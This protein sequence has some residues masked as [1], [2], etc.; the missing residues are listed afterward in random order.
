V[1]LDDGLEQSA[2]RFAGQVALV[3]N[4][5]RLTYRELDAAANRF[6]AGLLQAGMAPGDAVVVHLEN[7]VEAVIAIF[8]TLRAGGVFIPVGATVKADKL[9]YI[10]KDS[11][12]AV[13]IANERVAAALDAARRMGARV[14]LG[15]QVG[16]DAA[17][18]P[19]AVKTFDALAATP[20]SGRPAARRIDVDLASLIYTSGSTGRPKGVMLTHLAMVSAL[21]SIG[22]YLENTDADVIL[23]VL[24]LSF[25]YGLY[26]VFLAFQ[27]GA[28]LVL[29][30]SFV[31]PTVMLDLLEQEGVTAL[32]LVPTLACHLLKH[33][34]RAV[35]T[36][37]RYISSTGAPLPPAHTKA[38]R[39]QLDGVRIFSM[40]GLTECK[41]VA[42]L[43][44][45]DVEARPDSVGRPMPNVEVFVADEVGRLSESG[46]GELVVRGS[47]LMTGYWRAPEE[48]RRALRPGLLPGQKLLFTGDRF[49]IDDRG[50]MY[51]LG[52][53]DD[54]IKSRGQRVSPK[55]VENAL[56]AV[57][58]VTGAAVVGTPDPILGMAVKAYVTVDLRRRLRPEQLRRH[59]AECLEDFMVPETIEFVDSLPRTDSGKVNR[60]ALASNTGTASHAH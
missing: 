9:A 41:R 13:L 52:R 23:N 53:M 44:P 15:V 50:Y 24:P 2:A 14:R 31:Y 47:N 25:D 29:E 8:G 40:Y 59:C 27:A 60:R 19:A 32:P 49:R 10:L 35:K 43:P 6:G 22:S 7:S 56:Y 46:T 39:E 54:M 57:P 17:Q 18:A 4:G 38:L 42:F 11:D 55:E 1:L 36:R 45:E 33:D 16:G 51:F 30:R 28:R 37:L 3:C 20:A 5:R 21:T 26:Q 12:A 34:L 58:G 48:T